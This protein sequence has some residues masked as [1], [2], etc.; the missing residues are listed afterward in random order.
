MNDYISNNL[1]KMY[2]SHM[3]DQLNTLNYILELAQFWDTIQWLI[4]NNFMER[5]A[6]FAPSFSFDS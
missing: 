3:M 5:E 1:K 4:R 6:T 2:V